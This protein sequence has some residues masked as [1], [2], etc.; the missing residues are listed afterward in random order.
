[1]KPPLLAQLLDTL[2]THLD[3]RAEAVWELL[4][5]LSGNEHAR[6]PV[7]LS[8]H[9]LFQRQHSSVYA[10]IRSFAEH[11]GV[12]RKLAEMAAPRPKQHAFWRMSVDA[13][14]N[15]RPYARTLAERQYVYAPAPTPGQKPVAVGQ[16]L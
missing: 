5:A 16:H 10:A 2:Y 3:N 7:K 8:L 11:E 4:I 12:L 1:V 14:A 6:S 15:P 9:A 13:T